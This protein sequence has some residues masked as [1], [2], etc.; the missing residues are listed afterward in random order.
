MVA[1][2]DIAPLVYARVVFGTLMAVEVVRFFMS[3]WIRSYYIEPT[4]LFTYPGFDWVRP[5]PGPAMYAVFVALGALGLLVAA[6]ACF[7]LAATLL[8]VGWTYVFL[9][10]Q[11]HY[12]N[13]LYLICLFGFLLALV[14]AAGAGSV[15][16]RRAGLARETAP[17][18]TLWLLRGQLAIVYVY[19]GI[20]K[21]DAD[22]LSGRVAGSFLAGCALTQPVAGSELARGL[23]AHGGLLFDLLIVAALLWRRTRWFAVAAAAAFH[24]TNSVLFEIGIFPWLMLGL[25]PLFLPPACSR[26]LLA[27]AGVLAREPPPPPSVTS[28]PAPLLAVALAAY[29]GVQLLLPLRHWAYPGQVNWTEEGHLFSWHMKLRIKAGAACFLVV[30]RRTGESHVVDPAAHLSPRQVRKMATRPAMIHQFARELARRAAAEGRPSAVY[31]NAHVSLN[32]RP[33][34][35]IIRTDVDLGAVE[36][37][38]GPADWIV[39]FAEEPFQAHGLAGK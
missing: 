33:A 17:A 37:T 8:A 20:A 7:R 6:G 28:S 23:L 34:R 21:L 3:G 13:H 38:L 16:A 31:V 9:L 1:P 26:A 35:P 5:L 22:W 4:F 24:L 30:D 29:A 36:W 11:T 2:V 10:D 27:R 32:G 25:T 15:D 39:P 12:L 19:G 18:W 14:P